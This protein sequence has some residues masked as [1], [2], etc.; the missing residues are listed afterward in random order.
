MIDRMGKVVEVVQIGFDKISAA[1]RRH[2]S[3]AVHRAEEI[4]RRMGRSQ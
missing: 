3:A 1:I 4:I 2:E